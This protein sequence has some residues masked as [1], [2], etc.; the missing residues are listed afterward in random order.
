MSKENSRKKVLVLGG[1][2]SGKSDY[3]MALAEAASKDRCYLAT[4]KALDPEMADRIER[5]QQDRGEGWV[6][7]EEPIKIAEEIGRSKSPVILLDCLTLWLSNLME[8]GLTDDEI[9][10]EVQALS[11]AIE[12]SCKDLIIV[13]NELGSG[14]VPTNPLARRFRDMAGLANQQIARSC[15]EAYL[16]VAGLAQKLK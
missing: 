3:A 11:S 5:H 1:T 7:I 10:A 4:A 2:R 8:A 15:N 12:S 16:L 9:A 14:I 13:S 6:T